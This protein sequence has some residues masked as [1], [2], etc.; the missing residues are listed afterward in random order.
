MLI[1]IESDNYFI[2]QRIK[3]IDSNY[4]L[5][6][7]TKTKKYEVHN[8]GQAGDTFCVCLPFITLD[9]RTIHFVQK[10][11]IE[12]IDKVLNEIDKENLKNER[13]NKLD[14]KEKIYEVM[15]GC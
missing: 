4:L 14:I 13:K 1:K 9:E 11:R 6:F 2:A 8:L 15:Y 10:T 7:N 3:E 12:N 5:M